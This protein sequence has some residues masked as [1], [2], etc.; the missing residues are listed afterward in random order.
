MLDKNKINNMK[1]IKNFGGFTKSVNEKKGLW[2]N[3]H[4]KRKRGEKAAKKGD[5]DNLLLKHQ[6]KINRIL[7]F[8]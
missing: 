3:V 5:D 2:D 7:T 6:T 4:A 1:N 8:Y